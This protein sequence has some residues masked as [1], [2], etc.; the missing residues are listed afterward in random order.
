VAVLVAEERTAREVNEVLAFIRVLEKDSAS[1]T[2][3]F[4]FTS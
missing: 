1:S 4:K 2:S 3:K